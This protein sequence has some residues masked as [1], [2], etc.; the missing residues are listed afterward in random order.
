MDKKLKKKIQR[1][2]DFSKEV[3]ERPVDL[4][5]S[6]K[7]VEKSTDVNKKAQDLGVP[8]EQISCWCQSHISAPH[9]YSKIS[10]K[11]VDIAGDTETGKMLDLNKYDVKYEHKY[12]WDKYF[13][14]RH[15]WSDVL[16]NISFA[17]SG[18]GGRPIRTKITRSGGYIMVVFDDGFGNDIRNEIVNI[19]NDLGISVSFTRSK[20]G[21][22]LIKFKQTGIDKSNSYSSSYALIDLETGKYRNKKL[23]PMKNKVGHHK[24]F[25]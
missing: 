1:V 17:L 20:K 12:I 21:Y 25:V 11:T 14:N 5:K 15:S 8:W 24:I 9:A 19:C 2:M 4:S 6:Y 13:S 3:Q 22:I 23:K 16:N 7:C 10:G 18:H